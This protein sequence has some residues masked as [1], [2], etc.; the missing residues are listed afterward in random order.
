MVLVPRHENECRSG[1]SLYL[2]SAA[3]YHPIS[4]EEERE[5]ARRYRETRDPE[6]AKTILLANL[7]YVVKIALE[8][9]RYG[10]DLNELVQQGNLGMAEALE[11]FDP[12]RGARLITYA[13]WWIRDS[14][15]QSIA[16]TK[17]VSA[18]GT[19]RAE[20]KLGGCSDNP[21]AP[22]RDVCIESV[23]PNDL[24]VGDDPEDALM[25]M[26][27]RTILAQAIRRA[28]KDLDARERLI[29]ERR[30]MA[31]DPES[32]SKLGD[33]FGVSRE[34]ARQIAERAK[35][36]LRSCLEASLGDCLPN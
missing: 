28:L 11:R 7:R 24:P 31:D 33:H 18:K 26:E 8:Y 13:S 25:E 12:E 20:R 1:F 29:V 23:C 27:E 17:S 21:N 4:V 30:F 32:M 10:C 3:P 14:I 22:K 15:R 34:R 35:K 5:L 9:R 19:T 36:K 6:I 16:R 2:A